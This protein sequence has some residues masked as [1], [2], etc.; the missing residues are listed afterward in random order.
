MTSSRCP[1]THRGSRSLGWNSRH[2]RERRP[3]RWWE[4]VL[5]PASSGCCVKNGTP[6]RST[7]TA[8][9]AARNGHECEKKSPR[10]TLSDPGKF[11]RKAF[12]GVVAG[13]NWDAP[14]LWLV[15]ASASASSCRIPSPTPTEL[16]TPA[17][18]LGGIDSHL[19]GLNCIGRGAL[20][21]WPH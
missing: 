21:R 10:I 5:T 19:P 1:S 20:W 13:N 15:S 7:Q 2:G 17:L 18:R 14:Q 12:R 4:E 9:L 11:W 16:H 3:W 8:M 6:T